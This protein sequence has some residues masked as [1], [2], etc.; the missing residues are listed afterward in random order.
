MVDDQKKNFNI[1]IN[2]II[3]K[4][5]LTH[6]QFEIILNIKTNKQIEKKISRGAYYRQL[7]QTRKKINK[8]YYSIILLAS[9]NFIDI[10]QINIMLQLTNKISKIKYNNNNNVNIDII[11]VMDSILDRINII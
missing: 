9:F 10:K 6:K 4:S 11:D 2:N 1:I 7:S 3:K 8:L 5:Q